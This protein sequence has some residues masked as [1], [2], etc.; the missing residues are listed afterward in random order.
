MQKILVIEDDAILR[1]EL[2][3]HLKNAG[4]EA[5]GV[6]DFSDPLTAMEAAGAALILMDINLPGSN[7][8]VLLKEFRHD[9]NEPVIMLTSRA[10]DLNEMLSMS[11]G[12]DDYITKP[13]NPAILLLRIAAVLKRSTK[14]EGE[15]AIVGSSSVWRRE[16]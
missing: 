15:K 1:D 13:F 9:H 8:E 10:G 12:A 4:Y 16:A 6:T 2:I 14:T 3:M 5:E 11:Y 7:S